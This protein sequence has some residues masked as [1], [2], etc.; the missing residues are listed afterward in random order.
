MIKKMLCMFVSMPIL[1][2]QSVIPASAIQKEHV[3]DVVTRK[4]QVLNQLILSYYV[5]YQPAQEQIRINMKENSSQMQQLIALFGDDALKN[6]LARLL[7]RANPLFPFF[8]LAET[9]AAT[10]SPNAQCTALYENDQN[11]IV[12]TTKRFLQTAQID[13]IP[14]AGII[15]EKNSKPIMAF[16]HDNKQLAI[17]FLHESKNPSIYIFDVT[18]K[19]LL[20]TLTIPAACFKPKQLSQIMYSPNNSYIALCTGI[21]IY[22]F[23]ISTGTEYEIFGDSFLFSPDGKYFLARRSKEDNALKLDLYKEDR[24]EDLEESKPVAQRK[25]TNLMPNFMKELLKKI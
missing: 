20:K 5:G 24:V 4:A 10:A 2:S 12:V 9:P 7:V 3:L 21:R 8:A 22:I 11:R 14:L 15:D 1:A 19:K 23:T 18:Q 16:S 25:S 13:Y 17:S 6:F